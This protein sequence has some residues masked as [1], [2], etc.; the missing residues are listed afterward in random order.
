MRHPFDRM[1]DEPVE[2]GAPFD[3]TRRKEF[4]PGRN[5][6]HA[7]QQGEG[8]ESHQGRRRID[9]GHSTVAAASATR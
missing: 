6:R 9:P 7:E 1:L 5:E 3:G 8:S 2:E 4:G